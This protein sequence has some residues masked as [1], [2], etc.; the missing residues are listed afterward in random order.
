MIGSP[1]E[2]TSSL[3]NRFHSFSS[4]RDSESD[5]APTILFVHVFTSNRI[6]AS[7]AYDTITTT[8]TRSLSNTLW[9]RRF[10]IP[11]RNLTTNTEYTAVLNRGEITKSTQ[12]GSPYRSIPSTGVNNINIRSQIGDCRC[13]PPVVKEPRH[14]EQTSE[15]KH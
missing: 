8:H 4:S 15:P 12:P 2:K 5:N 1:T 14:S 10:L 13:L 7:N 9:L 3:S 6:A 11:R